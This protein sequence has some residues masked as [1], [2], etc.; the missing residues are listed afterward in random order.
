MSFS[1]QGKTLWNRIK[2]RLIRCSTSRKEVPV[3]IAMERQIQDIRV[4]VEG[5]LGPVAMVNILM[6]NITKICHLFCFWD[7]LE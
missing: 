4:A 6:R 3:V 2:T 5:L 1:K 7:A